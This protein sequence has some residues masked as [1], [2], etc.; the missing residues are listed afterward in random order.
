MKQLLL[1]FLL[2]TS[3]SLS[4]FCQNAVGV[5]TSTPNPSA[6][7]H[8]DA[9]T[10]TKGLLVT[11]T[12]LNGGSVPD[13]GE[14]SRLMFYPGK[15]AFRAG[16][17]TLYG[18]DNI[19]VGRYSVAMGAYTEAQGR[20]S[21][22]L[23]IDTRAFGEISTAIGSGTYAA[24]FTAT[25]MGRFTSATGDFSLAAGV[26]SIASGEK[27]IAM[28]HNATASQEGSVAIGK[29]VSS[30]GLQSFAIGDGCISSGFGSFAGGLATK[31]T[32]NGSFA[33]GSNVFAHRRESIAMGYQCHAKGLNSNAIGFFATAEGDYSTAL[34]YG[35]Y[36]GGKF[37]NT[38]GFG[39]VAKGYATTV[40]GICNDSILISN[41]EVSSN[42]TPLFIVGN[43]TGLDA[44]S[45][46]LVTLKNGLTHI[47]ASESNDGNLNGNALVFGTI[48]SGEGISSKRTG[49]GNQWGLDFYTNKLNR[50]AITFGGNVGIGTVSPSQKLHV[51]GN[52]CATGTIGACSDIRYK[53]N[54]AP[55]TSTLSSLMQIQ[56]I[57]YDWKQEYKDKGFSNDRQLGF[58]AQ[59]IEQYFPEIVQTD[60]DGYK[61]VD[62]SR[63]TPVLV[64]AVKEQ[65]AQIQQLKTDVMKKEDQLQ[66]QQKDIDLLKQQMTEL[67]KKR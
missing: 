38:L 64:Q 8:I 62:Y 54:F 11:G 16:K 61:A 49:G 50:M 29:D 58:S 31:A 40:V 5:G 39:S 57:Y 43:G 37:S 41:E 24:G 42:T 59:E 67:L 3:F 20:Y 33:F 35:T 63:M 65:Q 32:G 23:G 48:N 25:A 13:L 2:V 60:N 12:D 34:G 14:E 6:V 28:G 15:A 22:A 55:L 26:S 53:T 45:N 7:L 46:A 36:A 18:W 66:R 27:S 56:P 4:S 52:I 51:A 10:S 44:R 9:G 1:I 47:G 19:N 21:T 17:P 30:S